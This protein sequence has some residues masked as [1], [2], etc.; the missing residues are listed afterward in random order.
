MMYV[1]KFSIYIL[2]C[3]IDFYIYLVLV[4][5]ISNVLFYSFIYFFLSEM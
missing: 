2:F 5:K 4:I 3:S 1:S